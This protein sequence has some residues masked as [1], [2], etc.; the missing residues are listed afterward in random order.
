MRTHH[1]IAQRSICQVQIGL[2]AAVACAQQQGWVR[3]S[4][5][6]E[7]VVA[8]AGPGCLA[9]CRDS[10]Q[11]GQCG[12]ADSSKRLHS[13]SSSQRKCVHPKTPSRQEEQCGPA[14]S[15]KHLHSDSFLCKRNACTPKGLLGRR[16]NVDL[17]A[18]AS[19][20]TMKA[21][22]KRN[23]YTLKPHLGR[24]NNVDLQAAASI[25]TVIAFFAKKCMHPKSFLGRRDN[26]DL[27][28]AASI[29]TVI[30]LYTKNA[31]TPQTAFLAGGTTCTCRQ[32][33][34]SAQ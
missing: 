10:R 34:A 30:A 13:D 2:G 17:Q 33:Q 15:S 4:P 9:T 16:D 23:A 21:L 20:C 31:C 22:Y 12:P 5:D 29:C 19:I 7:Y 24:R 25:C 1:L 26:V 28:A 6:A 32:Q 8:S 27:Q 18:A 11:E 3:R 14:G